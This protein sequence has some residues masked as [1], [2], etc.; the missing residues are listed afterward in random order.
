M[1]CFISKSFLICFELSDFAWA[2]P[3]I[4][5]FYLKVCAIL[6]IEC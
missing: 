3:E 4:P 5:P 6:T 1:I 2:I